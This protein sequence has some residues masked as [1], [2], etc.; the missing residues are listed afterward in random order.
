ML[1][2]PAILGIIPLSDAQKS[3]K[4]TYAGY[5]TGKC[6]TFQQVRLLPFC[7]TGK[8]LR[9]RLYNRVC[10]KKTLLH[11]SAKNR[12]FHFYRYSPMIFHFRLFSWFVFGQDFAHLFKS[13]SFFPNII[14][15]GLSFTANF[16]R[17]S[18]FIQ[19]FRLLFLLYSIVFSYKIEMM[20]CI[21]CLIN[22]GATRDTII[23]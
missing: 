10:P 2:S 22:F 13:S 20:A 7:F 4:T 3:C 17:K 18:F 15:F 23:F 12:F 6:H 14:S 21:A 19:N 16:Q 5:G 8:P 1:A 11:F 9:K